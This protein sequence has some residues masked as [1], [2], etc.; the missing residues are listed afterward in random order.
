MKLD[1]FEVGHC[2]PGTVSH[3]NPV[4][5]GDIRIA[6]VKINLSGAAGGKQRDLGT[7]SFDLVGLLI[8]NICAAAVVFMGR[9]DHASFHAG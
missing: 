1:K 6:G 4:T 7:E 9:G 5:R 2:S 3:G 8:Q